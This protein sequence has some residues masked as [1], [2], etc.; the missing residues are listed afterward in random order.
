MS[1]PAPIH[2]AASQFAGIIHFANGY[3]YIELNSMRLWP[4]LIF[5]S[6]LTGIVNLAVLAQTAT[7][8]RVNHQEGD[9]VTF[10]GVILVQAINGQDLPVLHIQD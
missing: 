8:L 1:S 6:Q 7:A 3:A 4:F 5:D 10:L 2:P 9:T